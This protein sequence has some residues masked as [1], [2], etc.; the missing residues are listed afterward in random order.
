MMY[1]IQR[2]RNTNII[3]I[4]TNAHIVLFQFARFFMNT[5]LFC[6]VFR[7]N[8][9]NASTFIDFYRVNQASPFTI[10]ADCI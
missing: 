6:F 7:Y 4:P 3:Y 10:P 9:I 5:L 2:K 1:W 8:K